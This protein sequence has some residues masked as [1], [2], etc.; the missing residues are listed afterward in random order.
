MH[1][2]AG[3]LREFYGRPLGS[4][5]RRLLTHRIRARWRDVHGEVVIG[6]G[7]ATPY[8]GIFRGE[9]LRLGAFMP[10]TQGAIVWP[11]GTN[12][13]TVLADEDQLPL[14]D[15][16]VDKVLIV[17]GL[18][19]A[20]R[21]APF[22]REMWRV[23]KPEGRL[24]AIVPNRSGLWARFDRTPFGHGR[25]YSRSQLE[26]LFDNALFSELDWAYALHMPPIERQIILR[27]T[28]AFERMGQRLSR[29]LGG[30]IMVEAKKE[31]FR[32]LAVLKP[33]PT[34]GGLI[35]LRPD[36]VR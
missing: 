13:H 29:R 26:R 9:A 25:P 22:L 23:M 12:C 36:M 2:D 5:V 35:T 21:V 11:R 20:E 14:P 6:I 1:L 18:E 28:T 24:L 15:N 30:V 19:T 10:V 31:V 4:T 8:L 16:S 32:P 34:L 3:D 7:F 33:V 17:H 27:S